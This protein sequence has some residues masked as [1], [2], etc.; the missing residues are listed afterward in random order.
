M[1]IVVR[2]GA[3]IDY[4]ILRAYALVHAPNYGSVDGNINKLK[5]ADKMTPELYKS[6]RQVKKAIE[7]QIKEDVLNRL[8]PKDTINTLFQVLDTDTVKWFFAETV[9]AADWDGRFSSRT[10]EWAKQLYIPAL[11][12][13]DGR[14]YGQ[15]SDSI[16][17]RAHVNQLV[18]AI[19]RA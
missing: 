15:I 18:E 2:N 9:K 13:E 4:N 16:V 17:H 14:K 11:H 3:H 7:T 12:S 19:M 1:L 5:E 10:K 6:L 8:T